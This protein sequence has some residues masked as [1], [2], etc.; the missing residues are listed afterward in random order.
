MQGQNKKLIKLRH[1]ALTAVKDFIANEF[2]GN[3]SRAA[4]FLGVSRGDLALYLNGHR[5]G[6][7]KL[8]NLL[9][10]TKIYEFSY[11]IQKKLNYPPSK[12]KVNSRR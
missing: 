9:E 4:Q 11:K 1:D 6:L 7:D 8:V 5:K 2:N 3:Q 12:Q 10:K